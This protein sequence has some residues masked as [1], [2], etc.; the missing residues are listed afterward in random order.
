MISSRVD[1]NNAMKKTEVIQQIKIFANNEDLDRKTIH[2]LLNRL[3]IVK[4]QYMTGARAREAACVRNV[5]SIAAMH[6]ACGATLPAELHGNIDAASYTI[7][8]N[9]A[10]ELATVKK[11]RLATQ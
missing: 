6:L 1:N 3:H 2:N 10:A 11:K 5:A 4:G 9:A 7:G 8:D